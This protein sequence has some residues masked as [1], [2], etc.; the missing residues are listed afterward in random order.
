MSVPFGRAR[1]VGA[2]QR[3]RDALERAFARE[4]ADLGVDVTLFGGLVVIH[5]HPDW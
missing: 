1:R 5:K 2:N 3:G 4:H